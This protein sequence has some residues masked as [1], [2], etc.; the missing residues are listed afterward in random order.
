MV[1]VTVNLATGSTFNLQATVMGSQI[2]CNGEPYTYDQASGKVTIP[3][4]DN[5]DDCIGKVAD[6]FGVTADTVDITYEAASNSIKIDIG[7]GA[8]ELKQC[9]ATGN[10]E[11]LLKP[12]H[13]LHR[14]HKIPLDLQPPE[15]TIDVDNFHH[16]HHHCHCKGCAIVALGFALICSVLLGKRL[17]RRCRSGANKQG[18]S[19]A[20]VGEADMGVPLVSP[21]QMKL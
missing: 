15:K 2:E 4:I 1:D 13:V 20:P 5:P 3:G 8:V 17:R 7:F 6:E 16:A 10:W 14:F 9:G 19:V 11:I 18:A 12:H 21:E